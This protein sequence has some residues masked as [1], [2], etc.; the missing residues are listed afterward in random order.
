MVDLE[1]EEEDGLEYETD[2]PSQDSNMTPPSTGDHSKPSPRPLHSPTPEDSD[3][4][5][6]AAL[7]TAELKAQI[8]SFL[9]EAEEDMELDDLPLLE[10]VMPLPVLAPNPIISGF[11]PFTVSTSQCCVPPKSLPR[12]VYHPYKDTVGQWHCEP[13]GWCSNLPCS[14]QT[15]LIPC[16][17]QGCGPLNGNSRSGR[18]CCSTS[19]EPCDQLG[20]SHSQCTPTRALCLGSP[21]L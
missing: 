1:E 21:E 7:C 8:K 20:S 10:N 18:S 19:E 5:D 16:K 14:T 12:K 2:A 9:E 15:R 3:P 17:I 4:E 11:V 13:G 6:N